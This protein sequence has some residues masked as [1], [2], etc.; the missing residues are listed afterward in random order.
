MSEKVTL[1][2]IDQKLDDLIKQFDKVSNG[3]GFPRCAERKSIIESL[4]T[5]FTWLRNAFITALMVIIAGIGIKTYYDDKYVE[6]QVKQI[7]QTI[8]EQT[9][10][11]D[12]QTQKRKAP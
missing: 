11:I 8:D 6:R 12:R 1:E 5:N 10:I 9:Q 7:Y 2:R 3:V 4:Q